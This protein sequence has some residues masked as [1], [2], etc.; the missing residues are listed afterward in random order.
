MTTR[1]LDPP[2]GPN[3]DLIPIVDT[4]A[5]GRPLGW[6]GTVG[7]IATEGTLFGLLLFVALY[8]RANADVWPP[9]GV[10]D[11]ELL[12][13][14]I[15][16]AILIGSSIPAFLASRALRAGRVRRFRTLIVVTVVMG[17]VFLLGHVREFVHLSEKFTPTSHAYGSTFYVITGL[18]GVHLV[19]GLI[20]L[21]YLWVQATRGRYDAG[22]EPVGVQC[23]LL[24]WHFVDAVWVGV[25]GV[26]YVSERF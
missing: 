7:L 25:F 16:S 9:A 21:A 22:G 23:G 24:Y 11:P 12:R 15:R 18:H 8:L 1:A 3:T 20:V 10:E 6:W 17:T 2:V 5:A 26:L 4:P 13:S 19:I 14:G